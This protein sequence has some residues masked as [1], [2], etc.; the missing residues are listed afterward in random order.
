MKN[1]K[2]L[3]SILIIFM[4]TIFSCGKDSSIQISGTIN[5]SSHD[6]IIIS[7]PS[8]NKT[9]KIN[10]IG[11]FI[12]E[13]NLPTNKYTLTH[14]KEK[15][16]IFIK[17]GQDIS[18]LFD[19]KNFKESIVFEG[20]S[21]HENN[22]LKSKQKKIDSNPIDFTALYSLE[23]EAFLNKI[24]D[25]KTSD[26]HF[27]NSFDN[28]VVKL[29]KKLKSIEE[30]E[31]NYTY[32]LSLQRYPVYYKF[33]AKKEPKFSDSFLTPLNELNY[34]N[35][36][37]YVVFQSYKSLVLAHFFNQEKL[38]NNIQTHFSDLLQANAPNI[39]KDV[40][41]QG[42]YYLSASSENNEL[43][44]NSF[45][46]M[47]NDSTQTAELTDIYNK[48]QLIKKG[49]KSPEFFDYENYKGGTTSLSDLRG[50][51]LYIDVWA[52][53]CGPCIAQIPASK[54]M[55]KLYHDKNIEFVYISIDVRDRPVYNYDKW[56]EMIEEKSLGGV[57]LFADNAWDSKFT[58]A[59]VI[60]SIPRYLLI[61]P[62]GNIIS[63]DA[64]RP[65][66][67]KLVELFDS[68][69]I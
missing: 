23:E 59:F 55:E 49:M 43:L 36:N 35:N 45:I 6:S 29:D 33:Y 30:K 41:S 7:G 22:Y 57:Q 54:K 8:L 13:I 53:W 69:D 10:D 40:V 15:I 32:L 27:T 44:Y 52:T 51:Y 47:S 1:Y 39:K 50:K 12:D 64:P 9:I 25:T 46:E 26:I 60:N 18:I 31:A 38:S 5:N 58:K 11:S 14:G 56:R 62:D 4:F 66:D 16:Q 68:L 19:C 17:S 65:S 24:N 42:K 28:D 2:F 37:D 3:T 21:S 63:G 61:G 48:L 34:V 67:Q 20:N